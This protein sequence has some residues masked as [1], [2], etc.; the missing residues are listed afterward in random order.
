MAQFSEIRGHPDDMPELSSPAIILQTTDYA[1]WDRIV[2]L[3]TATHGRIR[4]IAK[5]AKRSQRRFGNALEP[6]THVQA[7]FVEREHRGLAR[8]ERCQI[9]ESYAE[10]A[11]D[12]R[13]VACGSY[14]LELVNTLTPEHD[15]NA[16]IFDLLLF[17]IRLLKIESFRE[18]IMRVFE[19]RLFTLLGY[20]PQFA[21]CVSCSTA[22]SLKERYQ[23][24]IRHGG[25]VCS[26]CQGRHSGLL[27]LSN[28]TIRIFHQVQR[29]ALTKLA[30]IFLS[31]AAHEE[32]RNI[33]SKF[34]LY[35]T[36]RKPKS[37]EILEQLR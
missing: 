20:Q 29:L 23:F 8:L 28:G 36:G 10:I 12:I 3:Y 34:L 14:L 17:F 13:K 1:E 31:P 15:K 9:L 24:S 27:P 37:L 33:F 7:F 5:G 18:E 11:Q 6:L 4:G 19:V 22:F 35:H 30:R 32:G 2:C 21:G 16:E 25:I 26:A